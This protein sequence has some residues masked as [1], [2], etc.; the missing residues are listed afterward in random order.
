MSG[1]LYTDL[2]MPGRSNRSVAQVAPYP[3]APVTAVVTAERPGAA[4][5]PVGLRRFKPKRCCAALGP[6]RE[7]QGPGAMAGWHC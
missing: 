7:S 6:R 5:V 2:P 3:S 4:M 1:P